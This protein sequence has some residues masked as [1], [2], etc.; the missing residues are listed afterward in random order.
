[1]NKLNKN[2]QELI[3]LL[4]GLDD[5]KFINFT[6]FE[7]LVQMNLIQLEESILNFSCRKDY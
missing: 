6:G 3:K 2:K 4:C 7:T 5:W 1:M